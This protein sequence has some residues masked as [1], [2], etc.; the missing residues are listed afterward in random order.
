MIYIKI[1]RFKVNLIIF[2]SI[3]IPLIT[4][5]TQRTR[6]DMPK[7]CSQGISYCL[8]GKAQVGLYTTHGLII[9]ELN[10]NAAPL[11]SGN[12]LELISKGVYNKT[13]FHRVI[14]HPLKFIVQ[15]GDPLTKEPNT[16][17]SN[18]GKG[19]FIDPITGKERLIPLEI[20]LKGETEPRYNK[21]ILKPKNLLQLEVKHLKG[22]IAMARSESLN[23]G[24]SQFYITLRKLPELD[25][26]YTVFGKVIK[27]IKILNEIQE[28]DKIIRGVIVN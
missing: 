13:T 7:V 18:F 8:K 20:K 9:I 14:N 11:T 24:S 2:A 22:S 10:G 21:L 12:F 5:C 17:K 4:S 25:G 23:S 26:R 3:F 19:K 6:Q 27:G 16:D 1:M 28:G 15:G